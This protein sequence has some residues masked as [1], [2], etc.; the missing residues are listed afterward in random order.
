MRARAALVR[1]GRRRLRARLGTGGLSGGAQRRGRGAPGPGHRFD[2]RRHPAPLRPVVYFGSGPG[3]SL[4]AAVGASWVQS[5]PSSDRAG[6]HPRRGRVRPRRRLRAG[7]RPGEGRGPRRRSVRGRVLRRQRHDRRRGFQAAGS[8]PHTARDR[9]RGPCGVLPRPSGLGPGADDAAARRSAVSRRPGRALLRLR[10]ADHGPLRLR[11]GVGD[12]AG[13]D[14][15]GAVAATVALR[16][17]RRPPH[18][19]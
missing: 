16:A 1:S 2:P 15:L 8:G 14:G 4:V 6:G 13:L 19:R 5:L 12:A 18:R 3:G 17:A 10:A 9:R 11:G 7:P